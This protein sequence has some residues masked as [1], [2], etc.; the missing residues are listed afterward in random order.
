ML[1]TTNTPYQPSH[2]SRKLP[3]P[4]FQ[5]PLNPTFRK[6]G[7]QDPWNDYVPDELTLLNNENLDPTTNISSS[8]LSQK[9]KQSNTI[10]K[11]TGKDR[12]YKPNDDALFNLSDN[13]IPFEEQPMNIMPSNQESSQ[14]KPL[15]IDLRKKP[16]TFEKAYKDLAQRLLDHQLNEGSQV[17]QDQPQQLIDGLLLGPAQIKEIEAHGDQ[18]ERG[19]MMNF[20]KKLDCQSRKIQQKMNNLQQE[21]LEHELKE[22][23][24]APNI[25]RNQANNGGSNRDFNDFLEGQRNFQ[26]KLEAKK[27]ALKD[28]QERRVSEE[29]R[30]R[31]MIN[32]N[33]KKLVEMKSP[34]DSSMIPVYERLYNSRFASQQEIIIEESMGLL[35]EV[36]E[37]VVPEDKGELSFV[38]TIHARSKQMVRNE[39]IEDILYKDAQRRQ[40]GY[41]KKLSKSKEPTSIIQ[42]QMNSNSEKLIIQRFIKEFEG[43]IVRVLNNPPDNNELNVPLDYLSI[44]EVMKCLGFLSQKEPTDPNALGSIPIERSLLSDLWTILKGEEYGGISKRNLC[45]FLLSVQGLYWSEGPHTTGSNHKKAES[46]GQQQHIGA[47]NDKGEWEVDSE[48]SRW[49]HKTYDLFYRTRLASENLRKQKTEVEKS[50]FQPEISETSKVLA[51]H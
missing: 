27:Q 5:S 42:K 2:I 15:E 36:P 23:T 34:K 13:R 47:F 35:P 11:L 17:S 33:S 19:K 50:R 24:F 39:P 31:P 37:I 10:Q 51:E 4:S 8:T 20:A 3:S 32:N 40:E 6:E 45:M 1:F 16:I 26:Q 41:K 12:F 21:V 29:A 44:S 9:T 30:M 7:D 28:T 22:C 18:V 48:E 25:N 14:Q 38:P 49:I 43:A 46:E